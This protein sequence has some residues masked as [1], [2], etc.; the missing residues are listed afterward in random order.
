MNSQTPYPTIWKLFRIWTGIGLQS[1]GG[2][3]STSFL[4]QRTF[5]DKYGWMTMEEFLHMWNLCIFTPGINLVALT[6][7]IGRKLGGT[8]GIVVSLAGMLLPSG[9]ITCLLAA[10]FQL[11]QHIPTVQAIVRGVVPATAG[12]MLVVG[13]R[14]AQPLIRVAWKEGWLRLGLSVI[15]IVFCALT[16]IALKISVIPV[17]LVTAVSGMLF[18]TSWRTPAKISANRAGTEEEIHD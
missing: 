17:L 14:F 7:L 9:L 15:L 13:L 8:W 1:F 6:V 5:I 18:F 10:G 4:I 2:G 12:I 11:I 16:I 3:A